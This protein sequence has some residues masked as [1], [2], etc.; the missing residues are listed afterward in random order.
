VELPRAGLDRP[1]PRRRDAIAGN[2]SLRQRSRSVDTD[3][4]SQ[5]SVLRLTQ[6]MGSP[7]P[8]NAYPPSAAPAL[9]GGRC[10]PGGC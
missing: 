5:G 3:C 6:V 9:P 2:G 10:G 4:T 7:D 1:S 8:M